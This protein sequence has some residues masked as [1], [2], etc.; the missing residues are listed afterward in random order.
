[1]NIATIFNVAIE[2]EICRL[3]TLIIGALNRLVLLVVR[4]NTGTDQSI[5]RRQSI[6]HVE[7]HMQ[8]LV[9]EKI[10][11]RVKSG[12]ASTDNRYS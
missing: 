2:A 11:D 3:R 4:R 10:T 1:M 5:R 7:F 8:V 12:R 9:L 6:K